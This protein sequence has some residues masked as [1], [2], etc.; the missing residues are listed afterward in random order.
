MLRDM[1]QAGWALLIAGLSLGFSA[2]MAGWQVWRHFLEGGRLHV[3]LEWGQLFEDGVARQTVESRGSSNPFVA[4]ASADSYIEVL[5]VTVANRGRT[6]ATVIDVGVDLGPYAD[7]ERLWERPHNRLRVTPRAF[8][9]NGKAPSVPVRIEPLDSC[10]FIF[11]SEPALRADLSVLATT[12]RT[13][14]GSA[15][16]AGLSKP[17]LSRERLL[18]RNGR[19]HLSVDPPSLRRVVF[20]ALERERRGWSSTEDNQ[21]LVHSAYFANRMNEVVEAGTPVPEALEA[22]LRSDKDAR[23]FIMQLAVRDALK[24]HGYWPPTGTPPEAGKDTN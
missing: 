5:F 17:R 19:L 8:D 23:P 14:R 7:S 21:P 13:I 24:A 4:S 16:V 22:V 1:D 2:S 10:L 20:A 18:V 9:F 15:V 6:A 12:T 3:T 11:D